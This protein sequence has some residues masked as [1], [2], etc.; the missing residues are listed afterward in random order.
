MFPLTPPADGPLERLGSVLVIV[1]GLI[2]TG[3]AML[4]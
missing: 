1:V 3:L 2:V 4:G